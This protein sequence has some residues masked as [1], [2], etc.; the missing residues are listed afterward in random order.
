MKETVRSWIFDLFAFVIGS[1]M[2]AAGLVLFTIPND[3]APG[4]VSGLA[5]ALAFL[6]PVSVG[7]WTL[8]LNVPLIVLSW[9]KLGF[10]P[11]AKTIVTTLL[12]SGLIELFSRI[13]PPYS[14]NVLLASV[15]GGVLCGIGMGVIFVRGATTGGT[16]LISLLLNRAFP[17]LSVGSLLLIVDATVVVFAVLVFRNIEVALYSIVTIFVTTRTIDAIMQGVDHAKVIYIVTERSDD[18]LSLLAEEL[19][20]GVTV[21]QGRGGYTR[22]DKHV[23]MLVVRRSSFAQTLKA[24][25]QIDRQAFIFVTDATE[26]HGEGFK[27][28]E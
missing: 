7:V 27:P 24:I 9:W 28:M 13:L 21:L 19:G 16:D 17:N 26:V 2:V 8:L 25:K 5:T 18:I 22:R 3:I 20:R 12:L 10:R 4:G 23:L 15:L 1:A 11:L 14:N 6:A